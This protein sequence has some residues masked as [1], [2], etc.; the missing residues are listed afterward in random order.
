M[1]SNTLRGSKKVDLFAEKARRKFDR[2]VGKK[3]GP[4][5]KETIILQEIHMQEMKMERLGFE[6]KNFIFHSK[7]Y[8]KY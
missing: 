2:Y 7:M 1:R 8:M 3:E 6:S 5:K 4:V